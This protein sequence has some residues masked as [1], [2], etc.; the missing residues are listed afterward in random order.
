MAMGWTLAGTLQAKLHDLP[1]INV[2]P[3]EAQI[4]WKA[5]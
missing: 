5:F 2:S 1:H 3:I 4:V